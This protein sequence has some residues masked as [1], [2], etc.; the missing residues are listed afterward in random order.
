MKA[1]FEVFFQP[2]K[3]FASL[4]E[5]RGAWII[6]LL[7]NLILLIASTAFTIHEIGMETIMRQRMATSNMSPE[8]MQQALE[9]ATS[10]VGVYITY[11]AVGFGTV[12][13]M[14]IIAGVFTAFGMMTARAPKFG[15]MLAMSN[16]A[17]FPYFLVTV[18]MTALVML[19]APDKTAL[20]INNVLAT[21]VG[22][23]VNKTET[24]KGLYQLLT[25]LDVLSFIE[26][27]FLSFGFSRLTKTSFAA[28]LGAVGALWILYV[29]CKMAVTVFQ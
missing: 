6:P 26:I 8:Q 5:R 7:A 4:P 21:N 1:L 28:G 29:A 18:L 24:S 15:S 14:L 10:P 23:F 13:G 16:L 20:D 27:G 11:G 19:A 2:G 17:F 3:L 22:A 9:R 25:S 12:I